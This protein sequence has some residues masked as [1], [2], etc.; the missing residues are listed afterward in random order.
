MS[1][2]VVV[3]FGLELKIIQ[4]LTSDNVFEIL[5]SEITFAS[6]IDILFRLFHQI[7]RDKIVHA[8]QDIGDLVSINFTRC[9]RIKCIEDRF[10]SIF[11]FFG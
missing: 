8:N 4:K 2:L 7:R 11:F 5:D 6:F 3:Y 10:T 9:L 1:Q